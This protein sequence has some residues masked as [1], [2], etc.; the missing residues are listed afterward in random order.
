M[1]IS[2]QH[3]CVY[4]CA[5]VECAELQ[6]TLFPKSGERPL[7]Q[8]GMSV[9]DFI[10]YEQQENALT[11][12]FRSNSEFCGGSGYYQAKIEQLRE[13]RLAPPLIILTSCAGAQEVLEFQL[14]VS[15]TPTTRPPASPDERDQTVGCDLRQGDAS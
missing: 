10:R 11:R 4:V 6:D 14:P 1:G 15:P 2:A 13:R 5:R 9:P 12:Q 8:L 3:E 7:E